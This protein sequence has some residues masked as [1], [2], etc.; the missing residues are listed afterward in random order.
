VGIGL[1]LFS[2][3]LFYQVSRARLIAWRALAASLAD[4]G[5]VA[6]SALLLFWAHAAFSGAG[7]LLIVLVAVVVALFGTLQ[8]LGMDRLFRGSGPKQN[9]LCVRIRTPLKRDL[10]WQRVGDLGR[11]AEFAPFLKT[12][13][14]EEGSEPGSIVGAR[15]TCSDLNGQ[16]WSEV[17]TDYCPG[18]GYTVRFESDAP[19]FPFPMQDMIGGWNLKEVT[20]GCEV[21]VWWEFKLSRRLPEA[22][23]L[24]LIAYKMERDMLTT[25]QRMVGESP[26]E[27]VSAGNNRGKVNLIP[28]LC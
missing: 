13:K 15:R 26:K 2:L 18:R 28:R 4:F 17:C 14:L 16:I 19:D 25:V 23:L 11:I 27:T 24:P 6:L 10:L 12:S 8:F 3:E 9:R 22:L 20:D 7:L 21:E 5:W 1:I